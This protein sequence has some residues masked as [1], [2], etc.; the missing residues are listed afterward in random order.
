MKLTDWMLWWMNTSKRLE[1]KP[2]IMKPANDGHR[3]LVLVS[4]DQATLPLAYTLSEEIAA[5]VWSSHCNV[6]II[7]GLIQ[8][9]CVWIYQFLINKRTVTSARLKLIKWHYICYSFLQ[10]FIAKVVMFKIGCIFVINENALKD[11]SIY[12]HHHM[13]LQIDGTAFLKTF[14][15]QIYWEYL[16]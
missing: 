6:G 1:T 14:F 7:K 12:V 5:C 4:W 2:R 15:V 3:E 8:T 9:S 11:V 13:C 16:V 10:M